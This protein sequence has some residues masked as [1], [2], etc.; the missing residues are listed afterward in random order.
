MAKKKPKLKAEIKAAKTVAKKTKGIERE[1]LNSFTEQLLI[2]KEKR[3]KEGKAIKV[4]KRKVEAEKEVVR[5][6]KKLKPS[7]IGGKKMREEMKPFTI[8][9]EKI[10]VPEEKEEREEIVEPA[11]KPVPSPIEPAPIYKRELPLLPKPP[12]VTKEW[13]MPPSM[14]APVPPKAPIVP[15]VPVPPA[16]FEKPSP[17][18]TA[19]DLGKLNQ[20]IADESVSVIQCDGANLPIKVTKE[21]KV[22]KTRITLSED[23]IKEVVQRFADRAEQPLSEPIFKTRVNNL[24]ISAIKSAFA[25]SK[26][27]ISKVK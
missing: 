1:F 6:K 17:P 13:P 23:E 22:E 3:E 18:L 24:N 4:E 27:V 21:R 9:E 10:E 26:F 15:P 2:A 7:I 25:G 5:V 11:P 8:E 20:L 14:E 16:P 19:L 12:K